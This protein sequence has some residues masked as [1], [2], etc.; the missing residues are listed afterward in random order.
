MKVV[1][2]LSTPFNIIKCCGPVAS[3]RASE[4]WIR[5]LMRREEDSLQS[6]EADPLGFKVQCELES[7][8]AMQFSCSCDPNG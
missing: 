3:P 5:R 7:L 1:S 6:M 4:N 2:H 8:D